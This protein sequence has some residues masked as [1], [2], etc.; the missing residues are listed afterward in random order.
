MSPATP[1]RSRLAANVASRPMPGTATPKQSG[2]TSRMPCRRHT[3][4]RSAQAAASSPD[5]ITTSDRTP[6]WPHCSATPSTAGAGT[7]MTARSAGSGRS[8]TESRHRSPS[9]CRARGFT[10]YRRPA[11][12]PAADVLQDH[13]ADRLPAAAGADHHDRLGREDVPQAGHVRAALPLGH[14]AEVGVQRGAVLVPGQ[15]ERQLVDLAVEVPLNRQAGVGEHL[16][17]GRVLGE[18]LGHERGDVAAPRE[19]DQ[20]LEQQGGDAL[21]VHVVGH[22]ERDLGLPGVPG[23]PGV[24]GHA[25][26]FAVPQREQRRAARPIWVG[27]PAD[28]VGFDLGGSPAVAEEAQVDVVRRHRLVHRLDRIE[29]VRAGLRGSRPSCRRPG[30]RTPGRCPAPYSSD[31]S[32]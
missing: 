18:G 10:V 14:G 7:A 31:V 6:R 4:S 29:V 24:T 8:S 1:G 15:R 25:D 19:R 20:V 21:V 28:P 9:I 16:Q 13:P 32:C 26:Q 23:E 11:Y 5:V 27:V 22:R 30:A 17:H 3:A 2:P 12:P